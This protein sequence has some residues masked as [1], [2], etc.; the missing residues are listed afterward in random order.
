MEKLKKF[1]EPAAGFWRW[2][3]REL[4]ALLPKKWRRR[5]KEDSPIGIHVSRDLIAIQ[6]M[7][8]GEPPWQT[9]IPLAGPLT[10]P[11]AGTE[12]NEFL[13]RYRGA[14]AHVTLAA[15]LALMRELNYPAAA[16]AEIDKVIDLG[17]PRLLPLEAD[18]LYRRHEVLRVDDGGGTLRVGL[19]AV[20]RHDANRALRLVQELGFVP[21][22]LHAERRGT[23]Q[24]DAMDFLPDLWRKID[25]RKRRMQLGLAASAVGLAIAVLVTAWIRLVDIDESLS[26]DLMALQQS[27]EEAIALRDAYGTA[28]KQSQFL[29][30]FMASPPTIIVLDELSRRLPDTAWL[31]EYRLQDQAIRL[32]G[33]SSAPAELVI[34]LE[35]SELFSRVE[36][37]TVTGQND[38]RGNSRFEM[39]LTLEGEGAS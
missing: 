3:I 35:A 16:R 14:Q 33:I 23:D 19:C 20:K 24:S 21:A 18:L 4:V 7:I 15:D 29:E 39:A 36:L 17:L 27:A 13:T 11:K 25:Q 34:G 1:L 30:S 31:S 9:R 32:S 38:I 8:G 6:A 26:K 10:A 28:Q 22:S 37:L 12:D 2:W 5:P